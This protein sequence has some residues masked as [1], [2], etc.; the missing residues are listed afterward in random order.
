MGNDGYLQQDLIL[1]LE[2]RIFSEEV[3]FESLKELVKLASRSV[4]RRKNV[5]GRGRNT[6]EALR[7]GK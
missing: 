7:K 2:L 1:I 5:Q 4:S 3:I 6:C